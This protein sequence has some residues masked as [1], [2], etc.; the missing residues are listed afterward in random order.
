MVT[1]YS[2]YVMYWNLNCMY[3]AVVIVVVVPSVGEHLHGWVVY[4]RI[5]EGAFYPPNNKPQNKSNRWGPNNMLRMNGYK[6][7]FEIFV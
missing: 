1:I 7:K 4:D 2:V 3:D 6:N 5:E